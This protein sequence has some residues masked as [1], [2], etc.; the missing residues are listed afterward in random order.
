MHLF[1][2]TVK[3]LFKHGYLLIYKPCPSFITGCITT[4]VVSS[5]GVV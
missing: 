4:F 1:Y 5:R 2:V 3:T